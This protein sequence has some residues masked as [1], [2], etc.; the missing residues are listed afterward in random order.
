MRNA[1]DEFHLQFGQSLGPPG[2]S[3]QSAG[4]GQHRHQDRRLQPCFALRACATTASS[5][6]AR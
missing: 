4:S 5:D 3:N 2:E 1:R 6:P